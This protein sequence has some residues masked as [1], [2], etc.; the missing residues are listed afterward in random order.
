MCGIIVNERDYRRELDESNLK[1]DSSSWYYEVDP[2]RTRAGQRRPWLQ[3][4]LA[5]KQLYCEQ[6]S[7]DRPYTVT[8]SINTDL[9]GGS[10]MVNVV[11]Y[12]DDTSYNSSWDRN[13]S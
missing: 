1:L 3:P 13:G 10:D 9:K 8:P 11:W 5:A 7:S 6:L 4:E 2:V 12:L